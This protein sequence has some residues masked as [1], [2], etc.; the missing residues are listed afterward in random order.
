MKATRQAFTPD[1]V[2][3]TRREDGYW[4]MVALV[5]E[6]ETLGQVKMTLLDAR[7]TLEALWAP[8]RSYLNRLCEAE[9]PSVVGYQV[10]M[11]SFLAAGTRGDDSLFLEYRVIEGPCD[12]A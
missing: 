11:S 7:F 9:R 1:S 5:R 6:G 12:A 10:S 8:A 3:I 2:T 4:E